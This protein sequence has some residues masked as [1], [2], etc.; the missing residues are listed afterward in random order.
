LANFLIFVRMIKEKLKIDIN[1]P[2]TLSLMQRFFRLI[3]GKDRPNLLTRSFFFVHLVGWSIF[4]FWYVLAYLSL[5]FLE[6]IRGADRLKALMAKRGRELSMEDFRGSYETFAFVMIAFWGAYLLGLILMWR[7]N[8]N[9]KYFVFGVLLLYPFMI[10]IFLSFNYLLEDVSLFDQI[11]YLAMLVTMVV[12]YLIDRRDQR[13]EQ[14]LESPNLEED[15][16][17]ETHP[18]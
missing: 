10:F 17:D 6:N 13:N 2:D 16:V 12:Y 4:F 15:L 8:P 9:F 18:S 11:A 14:E 5:H 7:K 3:F 1:N